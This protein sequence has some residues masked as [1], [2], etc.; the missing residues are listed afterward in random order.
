MD[1]IREILYEQNLHLLR[2]IAN[3][4]YNDEIDKDEFIK[5]YHKRNYCFMK[6]SKRNKIQK[7]QT[8][9]QKIQKKNKL[10]N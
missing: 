6:V 9:I 4:K 2:V 10:K 3:D 8:I 5:K 7:Y 1:I